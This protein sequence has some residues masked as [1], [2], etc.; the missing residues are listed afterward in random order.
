[1]P[2]LT[3]KSRTDPVTTS[4]SGRA[5]ARTS[6]ATWTAVVVAAELYLAGR[7]DVIQPWQCVGDDLAGRRFGDTGQFFI[8]V[9]RGQRPRIQLFAANLRKIDEF[10]TR[11]ANEANKVRRLASSRR[12]KSLSEW[13]PVTQAYARHS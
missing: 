13:L 5:V 6:E 10:L 3:T 2:E 1:M 8:I 12:T 4:S 7:Q 9:R 11:A